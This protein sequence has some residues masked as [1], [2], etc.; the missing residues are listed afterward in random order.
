MNW[1]RLG[2]PDLLYLLWIGFPLILFILLYGFWQK[3][4]ALLL[5]QSRISNSYIKQNIYRSTLLLLC[6]LLICIGL[7]RP[8]WGAEPERVSE[9]LDIILA[10]DIS[11]SMLAK[12]T[13]SDR[14]L[15]QAKDV[16]STLLD[17]LD[18]N[19]VG[20]VYFAE[21]SYVVCPLTY[22][23]NTMKEFLT[24]MN[25]ETLVHKGTRIGN[26]IEIAT[27]RFISDEEGLNG[28][29]TDP[30]AHKALILFSDGEDHGQ[31]AVEKAQ[32][33]LRKG[34]HVYCI[35]VGSAG[36]SVPIL[37]PIEKGGYKRDVNGQ[38]VL[39]TLNE[40]YLQGIVNAGDGLYYHANEG[41]TKLVSDL[42]KLEKRQYRI[43]IGD[44]YQER[45]QWF[46]GL[47][48]VLLLAELLIVRWWRK[49]NE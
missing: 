13:A 32:D 26:A 31:N 38:L 22:D 40:E 47:A 21:E 41:I 8:Q 12:N 33:G 30:R 5:F 25:P 37:L 34:V 49:D 42:E 44:E 15:T 45:Y 27:E 46:V 10:L 35:G 20:L 29:G 16:M 39:T 7:A 9:R 18:G 19:R 1:L 4:R 24:A 48:L 6:Y 2:N 17:H 14:R 28:I 43:G 3:R 23:T 36:Q 11:T